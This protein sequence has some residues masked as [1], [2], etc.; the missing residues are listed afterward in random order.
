MKKRF[1]NI[2]ILLI[3]V[4]LINACSTKKNTAIRRTYHNVTAHYNAF[5]N[6]R[7]SYKEGMRTLEKS[8]KDDFTKMLNIFIFEGN[9]NLGSISGKMDRAIEKASKVIKKHSITAKPK[10][11][12]ILF[13]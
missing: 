9:D 13:P 6:G 8:Q 12:R 10:R 1:L 2:Y 11:K 5:F 4:I 3:S 7:E